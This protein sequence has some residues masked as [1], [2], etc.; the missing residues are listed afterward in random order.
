VGGRETWT[1][2]LMVCSQ[3]AKCEASQIYNKSPNKFFG[4]LRRMQN[5]HPVTHIRQYY[6]TTM[7]TV[8]IYYIFKCIIVDSFK[9]SCNL[10]S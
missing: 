6:C 4:L 7:H 5:S 8:I 9:I 3:R 2:L 1:W 10:M